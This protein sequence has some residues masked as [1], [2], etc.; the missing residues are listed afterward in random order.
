MIFGKGDKII[1]WEKD[2][3]QMLLGKVDIHMLKNEVGPLA[4]TMYKN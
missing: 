2:I 3:Q 4:N 1:Q